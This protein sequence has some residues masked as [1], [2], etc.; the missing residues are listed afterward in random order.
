MS[1]D[2]VLAFA[3]ISFLL[4]V[5]PG[6]NGVLFLKTVPMYGKKAGMGNLIG[7]FLATYAHGMFSFFG[8][9]AIIL[10]SANLF[11][12]IKII[13]ALYLLYLGL[14]SLYSIIKKEKD[15]KVSIQNEVRKD[16]RRSHKVSFMEG[17][18]TQILNPK[19]SMFYLAV[20]PQLINFKNAVFMDIFILTSIHAIT[21]FVW[22]TIFIFLL[23]KSVKTLE[24]KFIRNIV[25][26]LTGSVFIYLSYKVL[27]VETSK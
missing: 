20:F 17:F 10:S 9:S 12:A 24:S 15:I 2:I 13:G 1:Y 22:F 14:K 5:S 7:I 25:Q 19:V 27:N 23:G 11:M 18:L 21:I 3:T 16:K 26:G 4:V 8:L 6:P